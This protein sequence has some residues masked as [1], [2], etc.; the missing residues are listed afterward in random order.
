M[1]AQKIEK[2]ARR[3]AEKIGVCWYV[4]ITNFTVVPETHPECS[5]DL[6]LS[7]FRIKKEFWIICGFTFS[8]EATGFPFLAMAAQF[9]HTKFGMSLFLL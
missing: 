9:F 5:T 6:V 8:I 7:I 3:Y 4:L 1:V 2:G